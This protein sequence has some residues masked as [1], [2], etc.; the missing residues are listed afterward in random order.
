MAYV[1]ISDPLKQHV[2]QIIAVMRDKERAAA[3]ST[4]DTSQRESAIRS[5]KEIQ[6]AVLVK[7]WGPH[8]DLRPRLEDF[9]SPWRVDLIVTKNQGVANGNGLMVEEHITHEVDLGQVKIPCT[10]FSVLRIQSIRAKVTMNESEHELLRDLMNAAQNQSELITRWQKVQNQVMGFL[11][12][13]KSLNEAVKLWP[14]VERYIP[15]ETMVKL[16]HKNE[17]AERASTALDALRALDL[18]A[19]NTSAVLHRMAGAVI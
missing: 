13:C 16:R 19:I 10:V 18:D 7:L 4:S 12:S 15:L 11:E 14:D 3:A 2:R 17:K 5:N 8:I 1:S 9:S 6:E